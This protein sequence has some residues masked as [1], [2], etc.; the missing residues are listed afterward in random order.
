M[1]PCV[2]WGGMWDVFGTLQHLATCKS[3]NA[4]C[5]QCQPAQ[6]CGIAKPSSQ[7]PKYLPP[8]LHA[9]KKVQRRRRCKDMQSKCTLY[10]CLIVYAR[11]NLISVTVVLK[12]MPKIQ[13]SRRS[14]SWCAL[15]RHWIV[16]SKP[17]VPRRLPNGRRPHCFAAASQ[18]PWR[19]R[20]R[21][22]EGA[23]G[24]SYFFQNVQSHKSHTFR[25][26]HRR[27]TPA[28]LASGFSV[29]V[30]L[31][32]DVAIDMSIRGRHP[33]FLF[34]LGSCPLPEHPNMAEVA[35]VLPRQCQTKLNFQLAQMEYWHR[36][37]KRHAL[38]REIPIAVVRILWTVMNSER[39]IENYWD[40]LKTLHSWRDSTARI[41]V[42]SMA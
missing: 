16:R 29:L 2:S 32:A 30:N 15:R 7:N 4:Y 25:D 38:L 33:G 11:T 34:P 40:L 12:K 27:T 42:S 35:E 22:A 6:A 14:V 8:E 3:C 18:C 24:I 1:A 36:H 21:F 10:D 39:D 31:G 19:L 13:S 41:T 23:W 28:V 9:V 5:L 26:C 17:L 37:T 20:T